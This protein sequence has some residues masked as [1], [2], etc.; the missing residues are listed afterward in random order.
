LH[1]PWQIALVF[2]LC[3]AIV[4][5]AMG[6]I[7]FQALRLDRAQADANRQALQEENIRLALY[8]M[9]LALGPIIS[10]ESAQPYF[11]YSAFYPVEGA[12]TRMYSRLGPGEI[13][14]RSPLLVP[15][16]PYTLVHFQF[17]PRGDLTSPQ[18][19]TGV[20][21]TMAE[22]G[23]TSRQAIEAAAG[24]L[25]T[26]KSLV[27][28]TA[29]VS[30]LPSV[31]GGDAAPTIARVPGYNND[32]VAN[33]GNA[34]GQPAAQAAQPQAAGPD[35]AGLQANLPGNLVYQQ[36]QMLNNGDVQQLAPGSNYS[37][38]QA[39][40]ANAPPQIKQQVERNVTEYQARS[41]AMRQQADFNTS[42]IALNSQAAGS[43]GLTL[44][45]VRQGAMTPLWFG[46]V[47]V[48]ARR[49]TVNSEDYV[50]GVWLDWSAIRTALLDGAKDLVPEADLVPA[51]MTAADT[52]GRMLAAIPACLIPG[53][54]T[55]EPE[56]GLSPVAMTLA[57]A[58]VCTLLA[59]VAVGVLLLGTVALSE[60]RGAFV[61][62]VTHELRTPLTTFRMYSEMLAAG[63]VTDEAKR[64]RYLVTLRTEAE[65]LTHLVE[66]V[67]S[68]ARI[69]RGRARGRVETVLLADLVKSTSD[70]LADRARQAGMELV[71]E[72]QPEQGEAAVRADASV[73]EQVLFNLIDNACKYAVSAD[74]KRIHIVAGRDVGR[75]CLKVCDHG[76]G[77]APDEVGRLFR[78]F[79]KSAAKAAVTA[80]G[81]GLGLALS[82]RLAR[83]MGG[84]LV[85]ENH[86]AAGACFVLELKPAG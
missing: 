48:L 68:Y 30:A 1:R 57:V 10:Q 35:R 75:T 51:G 42:N 33:R 60:R 69:E 58:W 18:V 52:A 83:D 50:Q 21:W 74:D 5:A 46:D 27:T 11:A 29:L 36:G 73:V 31:G 72:M 62:A 41:S 70:R 2:G 78:P 6:W 38:Q 79:S 67:L 76:P 13:L 39:A 32:A 26:L 25:A 59:V 22:S 64:H 17:G 20:M 47:L 14:Q 16:S 40:M 80:P 49:V 71:V 28:K 81:V 63:M 85:Y 65:R 66:N 37:G 44:G 7:S 19:P 54:V 84:D 86:G 61:S 24:R 4:L 15:T 56:A 12:Y 3:L 8:R 53:R 23:Y 34:Q 55:V 77:I 9:E 45:D 43:K 82:R